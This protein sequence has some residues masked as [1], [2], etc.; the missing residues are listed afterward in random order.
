MPIGYQGILVWKSLQIITWIDLLA[1]QNKQTQT[2]WKTS[3]L[4]GR[5]RNCT[6][7]DLDAYIIVLKVMWNSSCTSICN[8]NRLSH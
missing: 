6:R 1:H 8:A 7:V 2:P 5:K 4:K 3:S